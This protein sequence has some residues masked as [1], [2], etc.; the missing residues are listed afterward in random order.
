M[1]DREER[2][3]LIE[4]IKIAKNTGVNLENVD[5]K[6]L[7]RGINVEFEHGLRYPAW[8]VTNDCPVK[9]C[10][11]AMAHLEELP[12][13]YTR[14]DKMEEEGKKALEEK[15]HLKKDLSAEENDD[16]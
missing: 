7:H 12:D 3:N 11:I 9:T 14:L 5:I 10:K 4:C 15:N 8:N 1:S 6:E 13:Y 16:L 2:I